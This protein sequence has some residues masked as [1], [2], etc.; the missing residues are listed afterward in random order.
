MISIPRNSWIVA[1]SVLGC[2]ACGGGGDGSGDDGGD[3]GEEV[4]RLTAG[5]RVTGGDASPLVLRNVGDQWQS[6]GEGVLVGSLDDAVFASADVAWVYGSFAAFRSRDAGRTWENVRDRLPR[7]IR[8]NYAID[9]MAFVDAGVGY[10]VGSMLGD[11]STDTLSNGPYVWRTGDGGATW[12][13]VEGLVPDPAGVFTAFG[14]RAGGGEIFRYRVAPEPGLVARRL[15]HV[16]G[17]PLVVATGS[18]FPNDF[19]AV[20]DRGWVAFAEHPEE[21][22]RAAIYT[23]ERPGLPWTAQALPAVAATELELDFCDRDVGVLGATVLDSVG[24]PTAFWTDDGGREWHASMV[25]LDEGTYIND[26][27][28]VSEGEVWVVGGGLG[29]SSDGGRTFGRVLLPIEGRYDLYGM[30]SNAAFV[31]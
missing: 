8:E 17:D 20:G 26:V 6:V 16:A 11:S 14:V 12:D 13:A 3:G 24:T 22:T 7:A 19:A 10:L 29:R 21:G 5:L 31:R 18:T 23:S 15:D 28:C 4:V 27:E 25:E 2:V 30:G 9:T 1:A